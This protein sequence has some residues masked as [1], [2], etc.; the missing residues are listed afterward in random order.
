MDATKK[1]RWSAMDA[2]KK[3]VE[4]LLP[5]SVSLWLRIVSFIGSYYSVVVLVLDLLSSCGG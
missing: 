2:T 5:L 3:Q 1:P 4:I